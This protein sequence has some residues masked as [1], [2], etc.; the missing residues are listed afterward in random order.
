VD[1][2]NNTVAVLLFFLLLVI[3]TTVYGA[4]LESA[5]PIHKIDFSYHAANML[6]SDGTSAKYD[7]T[8]KAL[9][10]NGSLIKSDVKT[11]Q[12]RT[13][14]PIR[15]LTEALHGSVNWDEATRTV[16]I[17][18]DNRVI[19]MRIGSNEVRVNDVDQ[20]IDVAPAIYDSYTYLPVRFVSETLGAAVQYV[21][22]SYDANTRRYNDFLIVQ[23]IA[24]NV[25]V[26]QFD[27][28]WPV[29]S[30]SEAVSRV[31]AT[32]T[33]LLAQFQAAYSQ[34]QTDPSLEPML[35]ST[36]RTIQQN[37]DSTGVVGSV[38]RYYV[39]ESAL[40]FLFDKYTGDLF[41]VGSD[42]QSNWVSRFYP[43]DSGSLFM[44]GYF[45]S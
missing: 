15:A 14:V 1:K 37:I 43:G 33:P 44:K 26:D 18:K 29:I 39:I 27:P 21:T 8:Y 28:A 41:V 30:T 6:Y 23:G 22:G 3:P 11:V 24:G 35:Q 12:D 16:T 7:Q 45:A 42:T 17:Q 2:L 38:S 36:Y 31:K 40:F 5:D 25:I 10:V 20:F 32:L 34:Q 19:V 9:L 4:A 13:L